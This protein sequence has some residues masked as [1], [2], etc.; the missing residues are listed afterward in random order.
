V[1]TAGT[2]FMNKNGHGGNQVG[3]QMGEE[4][5]HQIEIYKTVKS[6][7]NKST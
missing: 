5:S 7:D 4:L 6:A 2:N 3:T 1:Y